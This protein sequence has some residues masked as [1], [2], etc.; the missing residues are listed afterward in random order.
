MLSLYEPEDRC[1][2]NAER[3]LLV[4]PLNSSFAKDIRITSTGEEDPKWSLR[5]DLS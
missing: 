2:V 5:L 3:C 4:G 1:F